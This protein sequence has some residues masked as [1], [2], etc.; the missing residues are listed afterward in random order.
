[1]PKFSCKKI[2]YTRLIEDF[3][4]IDEETLIACGANFKDLYSD[5][6]IYNPGYQLEQ[7][8]LVLF[9]IITKQFRNLELK[10]FQK[11]KFFFTMNGFI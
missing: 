8:I 2:P 7:G 9:D 10:N 5:Y 11:F 1:M 3:V 6:S 4:K